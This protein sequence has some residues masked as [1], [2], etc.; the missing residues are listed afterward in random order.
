M[1]TFV[2]CIWWAV[3]GLVVGTLLSWLLHSLFARRESVVSA[4]AMARQDQLEAVEGIGPKI[5]AV[6]RN[7]G[8]LTFAQLA[9]RKPA[10]LRAL[11]DNAGPQFDLAH[12]DTW[13]RQAKLLADGDILAFIDLIQRLKGGVDKSLKH[14]S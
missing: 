10:E 3:A 4:G 9:N 5:A 11:L 7:A 2:C 1:G 6:M 8:I 12:T 14:D 13:P